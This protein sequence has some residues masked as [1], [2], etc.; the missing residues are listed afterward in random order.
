MRPSSRL[1]TWSKGRNF[2]SATALA[3]GRIA[4]A[5]VDQIATQVKSIVIHRARAS[6]R[7]RERASERA[8]KG[9]RERERERERESK[10]ESARERERE[11][12]RERAREYVKSSYS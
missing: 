6:E 1:A 4:L 10:R 11:R 12:E 9:E 8:S 5:R 7:E 2:C 3:T